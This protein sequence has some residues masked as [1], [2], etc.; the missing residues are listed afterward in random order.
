MPERYH[1][2]I[3]WRALRDGVAAYDEAGAQWKLANRNYTD[4]MGQAESE[5]P[6]IQMGAP[7]A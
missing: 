6:M 1:M 7:L 3:V 4:L 5:L 2:A